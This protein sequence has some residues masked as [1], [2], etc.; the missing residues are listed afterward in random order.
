MRGT[1]GARVAAVAAVAAMGMVAT[2]ELADAAVKD[3]VCNSGEVCWNNREQWS[4]PNGAGNVLYDNNTGTDGN[5]S[6]NSYPVGGNG[7]N[8]TFSSLWNRSGSYARGRAGFNDAEATT[9]CAG[10]GIIVNANGGANSNTTSSH[11]SGAIALC[12]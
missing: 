3:N 11:R 4:A 1:R 5:L 9:F 10:P 2:A 12:Q 6:N 7:V 8:N